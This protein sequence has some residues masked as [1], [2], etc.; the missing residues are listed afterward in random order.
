MRTYI[1]TAATSAA[2]DVT[3]GAMDL[4]DLE[5]YAIACVISGSNI[6]GTMILQASVE[7]TTYFTVANSSTAIT[8]SDDVFYDV[9]AAGY[10]Y[11]RVKWTASSGTGNLTVTGFIKD[12]F[13]KVA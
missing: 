4:Q 2:V 5:K 10:R 6:A 11:A 9:T 13:F 12:T 8:N 7:G 3:S 1:L